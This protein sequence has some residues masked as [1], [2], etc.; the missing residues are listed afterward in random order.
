MHWS[1]QTMVLMLTLAHGGRMGSVRTAT[2]LNCSLS[3]NSANCQSSVS[4]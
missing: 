1:K 4:F 2:A 3:T